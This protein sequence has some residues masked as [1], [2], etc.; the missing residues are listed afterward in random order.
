MPYRGPSRSYAAAQPNQAVADYA[1]ALERE[2]MAMG[3]AGVHFAPAAPDTEDLA[4]TPGVSAAGPHIVSEPAGFTQQQLGPDASEGDLEAAAMAPK[5]FTRGGQDFVFDPRVK[6]AYQAAGAR[7]AAALQFQEAHVNPAALEE[8][9][10][11]QRVQRLIQ[12]GFSQKDAT[13]RVYGGAGE[14]PGAQMALLDA[15]SKEQLARDEK[16]QGL[17]QQRQSVAQGARANLQTTLEASRSGDRNA[18]L[19]LRAAM[20]AMQAA[21][22][23]HAAAVKAHQEN[24]LPGSTTDI[25]P[26]DLTSDPLYSS[27]LAH[28]SDIER[29]DA[30]AAQPA[31][32]QPPKPAPSHRQPIAG[33]TDPATVDRFK[34]DR[35]GAFPGSPPAAGS[36]APDA[37]SDEDLHAFVSGGG[38]PGSSGG[39]K[40][41]PPDQMA[42]AKTDP[43]FRAW[44][45][46]NGY[47]VDQ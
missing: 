39:G 16:L 6:Q 24:A 44:L 35:P 33:V 36:A 23:E 46:K 26:P 2:R 45:A 37:V 20:G 13:W 3:S 18:A 4:M 43:A 22:R 31:L 11:Q 32:A 7:Q 9:Q 19:N 38:A 8:A 14:E 42:R 30:A 34:A 5:S 40:P 10:A 47:Q 27:A 28:L 21:D 25:Q 17:I 12:A 29:L 1:A 15:K 41:V